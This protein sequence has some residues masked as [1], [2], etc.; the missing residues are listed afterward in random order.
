[1]ATRLAEKLGAANIFLNSPVR[2][3]KLEN[4]RYIV[5]S[6]GVK[7]SAKHVVIA[8]SPLMSG[9]ITYDPFLSAGRD[10]VS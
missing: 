5:I 9:W 4:D 1:M 2:K 10:Q 6:D 7:V 3:I 8:M